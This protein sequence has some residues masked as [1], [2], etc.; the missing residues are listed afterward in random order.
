ML[1]RCSQRAQTVSHGV[2]RSWRSWEL[3]WRR[4]DG[5]GFATY[6]NVVLGK[7]PCPP[8]QKFEFLATRRPH[9]LVLYDGGPDRLFGRSLLSR[10]EV[11]FHPFKKIDTHKHE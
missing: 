7:K 4:G 5:K 2:G 8:P 1:R 10:K 11:T 6:Q 3:G 9:V